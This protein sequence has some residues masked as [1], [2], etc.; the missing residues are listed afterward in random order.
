MPKD[1]YLSS[2]SDEVLQLHQVFAQNI[3]E[4]RVVVME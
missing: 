2:L 4:A 1:D 3:R